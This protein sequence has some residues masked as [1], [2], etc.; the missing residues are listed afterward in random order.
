MDKRVAY[1][2][3]S[4]QGLEKLHLLREA[5]SDI[6]FQV[7]ELC[8]ETRERAVAITNIETAAMWANK[9]VVFNDPES[10]AETV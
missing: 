2:H 3:P 1:H 8:P 5:F 4:K 6:L 9:S 7:E 10:I